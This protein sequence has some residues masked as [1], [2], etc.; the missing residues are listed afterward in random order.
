MSAVVERGP[1]TGEKDEKAAEAKARLQAFLE[2]APVEMWVTTRRY[3]HAFSL[4]NQLLIL[5]QAQDG[6]RIDAVQAAWRW[7]KAGYHPVKGSKAIYI[8]APQT[9]AKDKDGTWSC[10]RP[11]CGLRAAGPTCG[12]GHRREAV[13][14]L[15]PVFTASSVVSFEDGTPPPLPPRAQP[16]TGDSHKDLWAPLTRWGHDEL[17]YISSATTAEHD[18]E[19]RRAGGY[20]DA[21]AKKI[22]VRAGP[23]NEMVATLIHELAHATGVGYDTYSRGDAEAIVEGAAYLATSALGLDIGDRSLAYIA[24]W[25]GAEGQPPWEAL[26]THM[27]VIDDLARRLERAATVPEEDAE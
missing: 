4:T 12:N 24:G 5:L 27:R 15:K 19:L 7:K 9:R 23:P 6:E 8:W 2:S 21:R 26:K 22:V 16:L 18:G 10:R 11:G 20:C 3:L 17:G 1:L 13:F 25:A 14:R